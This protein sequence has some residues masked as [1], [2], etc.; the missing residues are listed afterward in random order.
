MKFRILN[1]LIFLFMFALAFSALHNISY[2]YPVM[3]GGLAIFYALIAFAAVREKAWIKYPLYLILFVS[4][5]AVIFITVK[6]GLLPSLKLVP[7]I[8]VYGAIIFYAS[9]RYGTSRDEHRLIKETAL[10]VI[11]LA[12][13]FLLLFLA[14]DFIEFEVKN[15]SGPIGIR[16]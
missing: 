15:L 7:S 11:F 8:A 6:I 9:K 1:W 2:E 3:G 13:F 12:T 14:S 10:F 16:K 5:I 4:V